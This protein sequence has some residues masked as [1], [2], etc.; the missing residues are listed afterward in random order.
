MMNTD[1]KKRQWT[2]AAEK[3]SQLSL[4][5]LYPVLHLPFG[6]HETNDLTAERKSDELTDAVQYSLALLEERQTLVKGC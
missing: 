3:L 6:L 2:D 5:A 4:R 1:K